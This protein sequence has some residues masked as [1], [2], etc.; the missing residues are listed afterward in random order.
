MQI[1]V[2][3]EIV[4][5]VRVEYGGNVAPAEFRF[6]GGVVPAL[7]RTRKIAELAGLSYLL[8]QTTRGVIATQGTT[9]VWATVTILATL[10]VAFRGPKLALLAILPT[11]LAVGLV[12]GLMG[13]LGIK[14]DIATA[15]VASV[16]LGLM[17][18]AASHFRHVIEAPLSHFRLGP[19]HA[20]EI[21][22]LA[23]SAA[24]VVVY[25]ILLMVS[26]GLSRADLRA[27]LKRGG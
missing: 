7:A 17:L 21:A 12:L 9:F 25:P 24:A 10:T 20:K 22:V 8:T 16:A 6:D 15:L 23:V 13:W 4:V 2:L 27:A 19:L 3:G 14:L 1:K 26:G 18:A 11:F 5:A